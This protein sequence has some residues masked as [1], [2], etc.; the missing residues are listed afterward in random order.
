MN[1]IIEFAFFTIVGLALIAVP[2]ALIGGGLRSVNYSADGQDGLTQT[3]KQK[4]K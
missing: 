2:L 3:T 4:G 1:A